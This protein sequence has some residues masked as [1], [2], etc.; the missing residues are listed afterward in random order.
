MRP[1]SVWKQ[2]L[3][4][5]LGCAAAILLPALI[6]FTFLFVRPVV[7]LV[8]VALSQGVLVGLSL[9]WLINHLS[10][11]D[12]RGTLAATCSLLSAAS[13][14]AILYFKEVWFMAS[15]STP[16]TL[17]RMLAIFR[18]AKTNPYALLD[19]WML[20]PITG[21]GGFFGYM[22]FRIKESDQFLNMLVAHVVVCV[23]LGW[24]IVKHQPRRR[25]LPA[26]AS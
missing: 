26:H 13:L 20:L 12:A 6:V 22:I 8:I 23:L 18:L 14:Y 5:L 15:Q 19:Q 9:R 10:V 2:S 11:H 21:H 17:A 24:R 7:L 25:P 16:S 1:T 3:V 4:L